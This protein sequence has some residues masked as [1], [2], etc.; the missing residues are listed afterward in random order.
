MALTVSRSVL[1]R[2][3]LRRERPLSCFATEIRGQLAI[4]ISKGE[5][6][7]RLGSIAIAVDHISI[8]STPENIVVSDVDGIDWLCH[9]SI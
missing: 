1:V 3:S 9:R 7:Y 2:A 6:L 5:G 8:N 4:L